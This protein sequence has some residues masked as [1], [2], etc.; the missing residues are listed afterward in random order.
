MSQQPFNLKK[1][2][3]FLAVGFGS[4]LAPVAPGT[5]GTLVAV[6][7]VALLMWG[8]HIWLLLFAV[9]AAVGGIYICGRTADDIQV[10][11]HKAIVWDEIAGYAI[12]MLWAPLQWQALL[13]GFVLFRVFD[14]AKPWPISFLDKNIHGGLGIMLDDITA[15]ILALISL[16]LLLVL[17]PLS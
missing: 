8:G 10:H 11:D 7:L 3:Q 1:W 13:L 5:F 6:P 12:T 14:I 2:Y 15:G 16:Q 9:L 17:L 4:G